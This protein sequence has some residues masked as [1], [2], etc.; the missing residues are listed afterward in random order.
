M[1]FRSD[2][3]FAYSALVVLCS[4]LRLLRQRSNSAEYSNLI[5][6]GFDMKRIR[7]AVFLALVI[8]FL[9]G[10]AQAGT[11]LIGTLSYD[12]FIPGSATAP[13]IDAIN[14]ANLTG[15]FDLPPDF[16]VSDSL[17]FDDAALTLTFSNMSQEVFDLGNIDPGFLVDGVGNPLVQLPGNSTIALAELTATLSLGS[18]KLSDGTTATA[19]STALDVLLQPS[20]GATLLADTDQTTISVQTGVVPEP[21]TVDLVLCGVAMLAFCVCRKQI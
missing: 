10:H 20:S 15:G 4:P 18:F 6:L 19:S 16:P 14:L 11:I 8:V 21:A 7:N 5:D 13:G 1:L 12:T 3:T 9:A 17:A 2:W